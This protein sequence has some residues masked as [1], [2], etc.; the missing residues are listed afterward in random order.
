MSKKPVRVAGSCPA[1]HTTELDA[2][3]DAYGRP[4]LTWRGPCSTEGCTATIIARRIK[5]T[6]AAPPKQDTP[7]P[8]ATPPAAKPARRTVR[9]VTAY[10]DAPSRPQPQRRK[11]ADSQPPN[12]SVSAPVPA[13]SKPKPAELEPNEP[14]G[15]LQQRRPRRRFAR[16]SLGGPDV[17]D[18]DWTVPGIY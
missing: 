18:Q 6:A 14:A 9:K 16:L 10:R 2:E 1:G 12:V 13:V 7:P 15:D 4:R 11:A 3:M 5:K 17:R 8:P